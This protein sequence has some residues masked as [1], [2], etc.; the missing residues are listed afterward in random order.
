MYIK[1]VAT[2]S[3]TFHIPAPDDFSEITSMMLEFDQSTTNVSVNISIT[4]DV[5]AEGT[6]TFQVSISL[7]MGTNITFDPNMTT[8]SVEDDDCKSLSFYS[9]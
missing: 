7:I 9:T 2:D 3:H 5:L 1:C 6:E 4:N 8:V